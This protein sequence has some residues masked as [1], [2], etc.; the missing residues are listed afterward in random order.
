MLTHR[1]L[2]LTIALLASLAGCG[3]GGHQAPTGEGATRVLLTDAPFPFDRVRRVDVFVVSVSASLGADTSVAGTFVTLAT[4]NRTIELLALQNGVTDELGALALPEGVITAVRLV[5]DTD[6]SS[7]T[8]KDG[9]LLTGSSSPGIAWQSSAGRP[10][11]NA[12]IHEHIDVPAAGGTVVIDF[13]VGKAFLTPQEL[14]PASTDQGFIFSPVLHAA[15]GTKTGAIAGVVQSDGEPVPDASLRLYLGKAADPENTWSV[16]A[17][18]HSDGNGAFKV[19]YVTRSAYWA[20]LPG[21]ATSTYIVA[22]DP[23]SALGAGRRLVPDVTVT[24]GQETSLGTIV[25]P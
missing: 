18:A 15:D 5:I 19:S 16:L 14:D 24:A 11:L 20:G 13:D 6:R 25:L 3:D 7:I 12:L 1:S 17:T 4:P 9:T 23:P 8:L 21:Q 10:V 2:W 22:V